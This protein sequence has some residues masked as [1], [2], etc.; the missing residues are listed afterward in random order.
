MMKLRWTFL[1]VALTVFLTACP[2]PVK[3][4]AAKITLG[5]DPTSLAAAGGP[6]KLT[7]TIDSGTVTS[8][9]FLADGASVGVDS[10]GSDGFSV[11]PTVPANTGAAKTIK[12]VAAGTTAS[13]TVNSNE[14]SVTQAGTST[15]GGP[16]A[17]DATRASY[18][19]LAL[20]SGAATA[21]AGL[22]IIA[23]EVTGV[24]GAVT[25]ATKKSA[26]GADV[27]ITAGANKLSFTY[28][29]N[30]AT[31][32]DTFTYTVTKN[33]QS[34]D[35]TVTITLTASP[36][37][38]T[39]TNLTE[40]EG[41]TGVDDANKIVLLNADVTCSGTNTGTCAPVQ[42][43]QTLLGKGSVTVGTGATAI[44]LSNNIATKPKLK[45][46]TTQT[47]ITM[48]NNATVAGIDIDNNSPT[49]SNIFRAIKVVDT[50]TGTLTL[51]DVTI[52]MGG[53]I[54][55]AIQIGDTDPDATPDRNLTVIMDGVT[56]TGLA[57]GKTG[58]TILL[59]KSV[60][61]T[62]SLVEFDAANT[63]GTGIFIV[64]AAS[65][66]TVDDVDVKSSAVE[67]APF[68][69]TDQNA[70][71]PAFSV[72]K[73]AAAGNMALSIKNTTM[74]LGTPAN[75]AVAFFLN[76]AGAGKMQIAAGSSGNSTN[77]AVTSRV[78]AKTGLVENV[79]NLVF[80]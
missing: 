18:T 57:S 50:V 69:P 21:P 47:M 63:A 66:I 2:E 40:L 33:G 27:V 49:V 74:T 45:A 36:V 55:D 56:V 64:G 30:A 65:S 80:Q 15:T 6:V 54:N 72:F 11:T 75:Q 32:T 53:S 73:K 22:S 38:A 67:A 59:P 70:S 16:V 24:D 26:K 62:K 43:G 34:K 44:T 23:A 71:N 39:V 8:V 3:P 25:A 37:V 17:P 77:A 5:A 1:F 46:G 35:G 10:D 19:G 61:M 42:T 58:V 41:A 12:Y 52:T 28:T 60:T 68:N 76:G 48:G 4:V 20:S 7:A 51:K 78:I 13:G 31:G 29:P 79:A 9:D 14:V